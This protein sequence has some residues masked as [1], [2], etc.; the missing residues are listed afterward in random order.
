MLVFARRD[1]FRSFAALG[2]VSVVWATTSGIS[3]AASEK[4]VH[5]FQGG[6]DGAYPYAGL[7]KDNTDTLYGPT[8]IGGGAGCQGSGC[9]TIYTIAPDGTEGVFYAFQGGD[10]GDAPD[11]TLLIDN[12]RNLFGVTGGGGGACSVNTGCG[13]VYKITPDGT[14]SVLYA[15]QGGEDGLVPLGNLV[16]DA[17]DNLYGVTMEG[18]NF[19]GSAC[20]EFGCGMVFE[21]QPNGS[22]ITLYAFRGGSDGAYPY[23]GL[24]KDASG[25]F[26]GTTSAGG[27]CTANA[28][29]CGT[30]YKIAPDGTESV[31]YTFQGGNDGEMPEGSLTVDSAGNLYGTTVFGGDTEAC[32]GDGCGTA[33]KISPS[34]AETVLYAFRAGNDGA[35]P[36]AGL[37]MDEAGDFYGTTYFGGGAGCKKTGQL[38]CGTVFKLT[39]DMTES[40]LFAFKGRYGQYPTAG[41]LM[42]K[43]DILYG[44]ATAGGKH[45]NGVVFSI[46]Q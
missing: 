19:N 22:K 36:E 11:G 35:N 3:A 9:G 34:G 29:G 41:L 12:A 20:S 45:N 26:Y 46:K 7:I 33:F 32:T 18:G 27:I 8:S 25:N 44:T 38:G 14:E 16:K 24:I 1:S 4:I 23:A 6:S 28:A 42:G 17:S 31:L 13:T 43:H 21:V 39:P 40:V 5:A 10:D 37:V 30:V 15:F 2:L